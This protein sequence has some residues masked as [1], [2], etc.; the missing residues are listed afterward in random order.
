MTSVR[1]NSSGCPQE[2][3]RSPWICVKSVDANQAMS[4]DKIAEKVGELEAIEDPI[5]F[6]I[7]VVQRVF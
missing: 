2:A 1:F 6:S 7:T 4:F 5:L 3:F